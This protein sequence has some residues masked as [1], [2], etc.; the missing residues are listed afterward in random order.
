MQPSI[1]ELSTIYFFL[2]CHRWMNL[3]I[4]GIKASFF[5]FSYGGYKLVISMLQALVGVAQIVE[6]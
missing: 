2:C 4:L 6:R 1:I 5:F 3:F